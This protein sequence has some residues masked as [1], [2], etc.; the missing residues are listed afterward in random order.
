MRLSSS[1]DDWDTELVS[2]L[3]AQNGDHDRLFPAKRFKGLHRFFGALDGP[4]VER[5]NHIARSEVNRL[6]RTRVKAR[7]EHTKAAESTL[8]TIRLELKALKDA[9]ETSLNHAVELKARNLKLC[10]LGTARQNL[11]GRSLDYKLLGTSRAAAEQ[12]V[13]A[14]E[15]KESH[16][17]THRSIRCENHRGVKILT[18][19]L[20]EPAVN[21]C[22]SLQ[23]RQE[24]PL[25]RL[26]GSPRHRSSQTVC[27]GG[28][29]EAPNRRARSAPVRR[30]PQRSPRPSRAALFF[31][32][33]R[34]VGHQKGG[35]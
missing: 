9:P 10:V 35:Q 21:G 11:R 33:L 18:G 23:A 29:R 12:K 13:H 8:H 31:S 5:Q 34:P 4:A 20:I 26:R 17:Q 14:G 1:I 27:R 32:P 3:I 22:P 28:A 16:R 6:A 7:P 24:S 2:V 15:R 19:L 30:R 25:R